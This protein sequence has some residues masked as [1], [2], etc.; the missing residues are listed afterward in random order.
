MN[1]LFKLLSE[2]EK[3]IKILILFYTFY[4]SLV[5]GASWDEEY[6]H[7]IGAINLKYL[8][9]FGMVEENF[10]QK[11]RFSTLYWSL[12]SLVSQIVPKKYSLEIHHII[13]T[14]FGLMI[15][16][17]VHQITKKIF[18][19]TIA[20]TSSIFL[21]LLPFFF[22]HL[23]INNKDI[24]ITFA[25]VWIIYYLIKYTFKNF[26]LK[27]RILV[28]FKVAILSALGTGIQL[29]FL[30]SLAPIL[31]IFLFYFIVSKKKNLITIF[32]DLFIYFLFFY[33]ILLLFW[34]DTHS[35]V[36][37]LPF[38]YFM[39]TFSLSVGWP[40]NLVNGKY[41]LSNEV[42]NQYLL[43]HYLYKL[44]EFI[45]FLYII[46]VPVIVIKYK[47]L[48]KDFKNFKYKILILILLLIFPNLV[49]IFITFPIYDGIRLFLWVTPYLVII[50]AITFFCLINEKSSF[51][52]FVKIT[53]VVLFSFHMI[54]FIKITPYHYTYLNYFSGDA[55]NR[56]KKFENDYW[57][58]SLKELI[59]S[60]NLIEDK[61]KYSTCGVNPYIAKIYMKQRY[62][63]A[64]YTDINKAS[65]VIMTNRTL[66]SEKKQSISNCYDEY[67]FENT[68]TVKRNGLILSIIKKIK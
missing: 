67:S 28:L 56:Y 37:I 45:I 3:Q 31:I 1:K 58:T 60:S 2:Y 22:G 44:P 6:Y 29:F 12:S 35:N 47:K 41:V 64:V 17:G 19:K 33:S 46:S 25:H 65:Y 43:I 9:S 5:I 16:V 20:R 27:N 32:T 24:I 59:L 55:K 53:L 36:L 42:P 26:D 63:N 66:Y 51:F 10:D 14:F 48:K 21:L 4:C 50:P 13:N 54:N 18:N 57:S 11:F 15:I 49:L 38:R 30:G 68:S 34:V 7:K 23:A 61:I 62:R 39:E 40:F 8:L 52:L